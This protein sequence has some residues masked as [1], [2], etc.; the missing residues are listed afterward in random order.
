MEENTINTEN[1]AI[2]ESMVREAKSAPEPGTI[3]AGQVLHQGDDSAPAP[4]VALKLK[5]AGY[6]YI[7]DNRTGE[8]SITNMNMLRAQLDKKREDGSQVFT[9][10]NPHIKLKRGSLKC[11]L[12]KDSPN[13]A[14]F[15]ELGL[16]ICTK[17]NLTSPYQVIR[18]MQRRHH[19]EWET[20]EAERITAEKADEKA[21]R[22]ALRDILIGKATGNNPPDRL[23]AI[24]SDTMVEASVEK[25]DWDSAE[26]Y[27]S[28]K[29]KAA[30]AQP[31][32]K[33]K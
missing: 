7:W 33:K 23:D 8:M 17:S 10:I 31:K 29:D 14:H 15:T 27:V 22:K 24:T 32:K 18:H 5:S 9:T 26:V 16:A 28:D 25:L 2:I 21:D 30:Q 12:H 6:A 11:M 1:A 4:Q 13:R 19:Q 20:I 3:K